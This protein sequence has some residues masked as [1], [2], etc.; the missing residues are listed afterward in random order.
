MSEKRSFFTLLEVVIALAILGISL[1]V[2]LQLMMSSQKRIAKSRDKWRETH[3]L[4]QG[5]EYLLLHERDTVN[6]P[7]RFFPYNDYS[8]H[9]NYDEAENLPEEYM[10]S[11]GQL[12][13][14]ACKISLIRLSDGKVVETITVDRIGYETELEEQ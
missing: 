11:A 8:I 7:T 13:L 9:C 4:M 2:L 14:Y 12:T 6:V 10:G 3:M 1:T 5:A